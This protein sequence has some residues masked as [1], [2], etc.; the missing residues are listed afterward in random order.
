M[1]ARTFASIVP[2]QSASSLMRWSIKCGRRFRRD[3]LFHVQL[4]LSHLSYSPL[5]HLVAYGS[6]NKYRPVNRSKASGSSGE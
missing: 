5:R 1:I 6:T 3:G 4:P 2:R